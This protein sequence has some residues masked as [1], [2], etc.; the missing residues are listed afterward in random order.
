MLF[1]FK[2]PL[3]LPRQI[4]RGQNEELNTHGTETA[5]LKYKQK[6]QLKQA[7]NSLRIQFVVHPFTQVTNLQT[8]KQE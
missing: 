5:E 7:K 6:T 2:A 8:L 3:L 4:C 1:G